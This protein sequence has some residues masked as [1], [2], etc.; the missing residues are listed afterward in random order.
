MPYKKN[1]RRRA[2]KRRRVNRRRRY[3]KKSINN[4]NLVSGIPQRNFVKLRYAE[5][6]TLTGSSASAFDTHV[7]SGNNTFDPN[8]S[9]GGHQPMGYDEWGLFYYRIMCRGSKIVCRFSTTTSNADGNTTLF[10]MP[11]IDVLTTPNWERFAENQLGKSTVIGPY[12]GSG[13]KT[14]S[15]YKSTKFMFGDGNGLE[16]N[17]YGSLIGAAPPRLWQWLIGAE[18]QNGAN[19]DPVYVDVV[20]TYY[21]ELYDRK[22]LP[23]S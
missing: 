16:Q 12:S 10:L 3:A 13:T 19:L 21:C 15:M 18:T 17:E 6:I 7:M 9:L 5:R 20:I 1:Y 2:P 14:M 23:Q 8:Y 22:P 11:S 4:K